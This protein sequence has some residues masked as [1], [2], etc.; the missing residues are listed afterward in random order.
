MVGIQFGMLRTIAAYSLSCRISTSLS[1]ETSEKK[2]VSLTLGLIQIRRTNFEGTAGYRRGHE[3]ITSWR[4]EKASSHKSGN[5]AHEA[6]GHPREIY[7]IVHLSHA[8][9]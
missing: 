2:L 4:S 8:D 3:R 1:L 5:V 6:D 7:R 9:T